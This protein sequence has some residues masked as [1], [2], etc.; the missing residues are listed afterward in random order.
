[1]NVYLNI[2]NGN[3]SSGK[4]KKGVSWVVDKFLNLFLIAL[5]S[6]GDMDTASGD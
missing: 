2:K 6:S 4:K 3:N 5:W 1:M